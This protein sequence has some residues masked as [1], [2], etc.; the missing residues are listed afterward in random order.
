MNTE[1]ERLYTCPFIPSEKDIKLCEIAK[2]YHEQCEAFDK[3]IC[4]WSYGAECYMPVTYDQRK[5]TTENARM[6]RNILFSKNT[7]I[8]PQEIKKAISNY[9]H[10][11]TPP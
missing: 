3:S 9:Q 4:W 6:L 1:F 10:R 8:D 7:D 2:Y 11:E 5:L